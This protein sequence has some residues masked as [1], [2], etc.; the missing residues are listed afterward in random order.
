[1][2]PVMT[3][4]DWVIWGGRSLPG[5]LPVHPH[6]ATRYS[7]PS[8]KAWRRRIAESPRVMLESLPAAF[9]VVRRP[10]IA[11]EPTQED[12]KCA[13]WLASGGCG[14]VPPYARHAGVRLQ[15]ARHL[16]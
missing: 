2:Y 16:D 9:P 3:R 15:R 6:A 8:Y 4:P 11:A 1:M 14:R 12:K 13:A 10:G 5:S 7:L